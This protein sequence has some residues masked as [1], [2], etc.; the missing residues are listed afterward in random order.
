MSLGV[1]VVPLGVPSLDLLEE[2]SLRRDSAPEALPTEMTA[3]DLGHMQPTT[4]FGS[5]MDLSF[6]RDAV[7]LRRI[8]SFRQ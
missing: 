8:K 6:S 4:V 2:G 7:R 1:L 3:F 5:I